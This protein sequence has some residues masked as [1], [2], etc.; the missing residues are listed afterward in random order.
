MKLS[1]GA[2]VLSLTDLKLSVDAK[3]DVKPAAKT[4]VKP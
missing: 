2:V 1:D 4:E 3:P